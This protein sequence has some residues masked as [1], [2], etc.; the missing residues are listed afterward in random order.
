M[1][2]DCRGNSPFQARIY[3]NGMWIAYPLPPTAKAT[4]IFALAK[5][6]GRTQIQEVHHIGKGKYH[7]AAMRLVDWVMLNQQRP[8][9]GEV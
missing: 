9:G 5:Q 6:Q 4:E 8:L 1:Y 2:L 7:S 3:T